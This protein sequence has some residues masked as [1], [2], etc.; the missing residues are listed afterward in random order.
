M[1]ESRKMR[2]K[3]RRAYRLRAWNEY[4]SIVQHDL[5]MEKLKFL[6]VASYVIKGLNL[7]MKAYKSSYAK[8]GGQISRLLEM[9][10]AR[11]IVLQ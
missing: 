11:R 7:E 2:H 1:K 5:D 6:D 10:D 8:F 4:E 3:R 9:K